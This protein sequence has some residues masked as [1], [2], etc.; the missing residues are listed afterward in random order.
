MTLDGVKWEF[1]YG[2][3]GLS[4]VIIESKRGVAHETVI[5]DAARRIKSFLRTD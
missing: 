3:D 1:I 4:E 2:P 5:V